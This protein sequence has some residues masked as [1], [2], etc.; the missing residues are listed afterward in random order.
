MERLWGRCSQPAACLPAHLPAQAFA[1]DAP[2]LPLGASAGL[3]FPL[4][5]C[6]KGQAGEQVFPS[7]AQP[8]A[9]PPAR[10]QVNT[11]FQLGLVGACMAQAWLGLPGPAVVDWVAAGTAVTTVWSAGAYARAYMAGNMLQAGAG[12]N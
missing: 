12:K 5:N 3:A 4:Q 7:P 2:G 10:P 8:P 11:C 1:A 9:R 6:G